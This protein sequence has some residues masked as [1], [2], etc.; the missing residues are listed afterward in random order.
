MFNM[1]IL[2]LAV[3][4]VLLSSVAS[5]P[6]EY[7]TCYDKV[8]PPST[9]GCSKQRL[10]TDDNKYLDTIVI[11]WH[12]K[13]EVQKHTD[14]ILNPYGG[15]VEDFETSASFKIGKGGIWIPE[16]VNATIYN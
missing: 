13:D 11:C 7:P 14:R 2:L 3:L 5:A 8:C 12:K 4:G 1:K 10:T 6:S 9:T 16:F 15:P